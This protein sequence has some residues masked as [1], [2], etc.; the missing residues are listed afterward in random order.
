MDKLRGKKN[1]KVAYRRTESITNLE[2]D[3]GRRIAIL[4]GLK[5][6]GNEKARL[7][8]DYYGS[9]AG[10]LEA[11]LDPGFMMNEHRPKGFGEKT[12]VENRLLFGLTQEHMR[13]CVVSKEK[14]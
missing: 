4:A 12:V 2:D 6:I 7:L 9:V 13:L 5:H 8:L 14:R 1:D 11:V 3:E 10:A